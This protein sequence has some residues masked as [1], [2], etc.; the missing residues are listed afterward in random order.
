MVAG[1]EL[2]TDRLLLRPW[3]ESDCEPFA[4]LNADPEVMR[5]LQGPR[6]RE[7]SD[8]SIASMERQF[9]EQGWGLWAL[10]VIATGEFI[11]FT[12][13]ARSDFDAHFTPAVEVGWR[14]ARQAWGHGYA[15]EAGA[16]AVRF[17]LGPGG[18][19]DIMSW[20]AAIN[21]PSRAVMARLGFRHDPAADFEHPRVPPG[22]PIRPH[23]LYRLP[24]D[25]PRSYPDE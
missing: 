23:V 12:G 5:Y 17:G 8:A 10:E 19:P 1:P 2:R 13:L 4:Q 22:D 20:T 3:R 24:T 6:S 25:G 16:A 15:T 21:S 9:A 11:G 7:R 18:I 14:L